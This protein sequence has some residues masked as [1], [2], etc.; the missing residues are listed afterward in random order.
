M[1]EVNFKADPTVVS[2]AEQ[3]Q[4]L[5]ARAANLNIV[6]HQA[7]TEAGKWLMDIKTDLAKIEA[8]RVRITKPMNDALRETNAQAN[9]AKAPLIETEGKI[10]AAI[11]AYNK[12]QERIRIAAQRKADD[13]ARKEQQRLQEIADRARAK[14]TQEAQERREAAE[15]EA[16]AGRQAEAD[17]LRAQA[18]KIEEKG[19]AKADSF[20]NR[21]ETTVAAI[22][23]RETPKVAGITQRDN[24]VYRITDP[25]K[26][27]AAFLMP[28]EVKI[29]KAVKSLK[30]EAA[31]L[32]GAGVEIKNEPIIGAGRAAS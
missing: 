5:A 16:A 8:A 9:A 6:T 32:I 3:H 11:L 4:Q 23:P 24:W 31:E 18:A 10:K 14:A 7:F 2:V 19:E 1:D 29:G 13:E 17:R 21:A 28:N 20:Q 25:T 15:R 30:L 22:V 12:E 26:I 27:N